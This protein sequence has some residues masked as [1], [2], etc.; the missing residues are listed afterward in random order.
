MKVLLSVKAGR[1]CCFWLFNLLRDMHRLL[2]APDYPLLVSVAAPAYP[3]LRTML[4]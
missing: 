4:Q 3:G 2:E 1:Y